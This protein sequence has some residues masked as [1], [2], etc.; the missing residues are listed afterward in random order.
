VRLTVAILMRSKFGGSAAEYALMLSLFAIAI[1]GGATL[2]GTAVNAPFA[3][4]ST[5]FTP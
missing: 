1:I 5:Q 2:L 4:M 3:L